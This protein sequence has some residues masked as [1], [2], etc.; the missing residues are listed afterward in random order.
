MYAQVSQVVKANILNTLLSTMHMPAVHDRTS[1]KIHFSLCY[2]CTMN[3]LDQ[4]NR[5]LTFQGQ[6]IGDVTQCC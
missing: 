6:K 4:A 2:G 1:N 3:D 5:T